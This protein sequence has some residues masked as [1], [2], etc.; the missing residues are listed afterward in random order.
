M[1]SE[2]QGCYKI[3]VNHASAYLHQLDAYANRVHGKV[4]I[5]RLDEGVKQREERACDML[6]QTRD[7]LQ[8]HQNHIHRCW[9]PNNFLVLDP[10]LLLAF[11]DASEISRKKIALIVDVE[12]ET[13]KENTN[14]V[15]S[16]EEQKSCR[17]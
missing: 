11:V 16:F 13:Q 5:V 3:H 15:S 9:L 12:Y 7:V 10:S 8:I 17:C 6:E 14:V 2:N 4:H 1:L